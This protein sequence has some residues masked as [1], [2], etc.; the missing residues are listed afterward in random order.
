MSLM[1]HVDGT[2]WGEFHLLHKERMEAF[3]MDAFDYHL[4]LVCL[5]LASS[6]CLAGLQCCLAQGVLKKESHLFP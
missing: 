1:E 5:D 3:V 6:C 4:I 2:Q